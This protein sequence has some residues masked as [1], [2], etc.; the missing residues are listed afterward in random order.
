MT[1]GLLLSLGLVVLAHLWRSTANRASRTVSW[2]EIHPDG[3][4]VVWQD[5]RHGFAGTRR[6]RLTGAILIA[7]FG[8]AD[9]KT[10]IWVGIAGARQKQEAAEIVARAAGARL[11]DEGIPP[12]PYSN[13]TAWRLGITE[14]KPREADALN[15]RERHLDEQLAPEQPTFPEAADNYFSDHNDALAVIC[16][17]GEKPTR[18]HVMAMTTVRGL[19]TDIT[20]AATV[21]RRFLPLSYAWVPAVLAAT[22][23]ALPVIRSSAN[24]WD[25]A[26]IAVVTAWFARFL[27]RSAKHPPTLV[28][29]R[30]GRVP[31]FTRAARKGAPLPVWQMGEWAAGTDRAGVHAPLKNAPAEVTQRSGACIGQDPR[32]VEC[33]LP[34]EDRYRGFMCYGDPGKGKSTLMRGMLKADADRRAEQNWLSIIWIETKS[35][36]EGAQPAAELMRNAGLNPLVLV[37]AEINGPRLELA[38]RSNPASAARLLTEAMRY[39]YDASDIYEQSAEILAA[40]FEAAAAFDPEDAARIGL[41]EEQPNLIEVAFRLLGG[42]P[43]LHERAKR[44]LADH[45]PETH[46]QKLQRY[47]EEGPRDYKMRVEPVRNKL[48]GLLAARGMFEPARRQSVTFGDLLAV[49]QPVV[50]DLAPRDGASGHYTNLTAQRMAAMAMFALWDTIRRTC[51]GWQAAGKNIAIYSDELKDV[52]GFGNGHLEVV[53]AIADQGRSLGVIPVFGTQRPDQLRDATREAVNSFGTQ[54]YFG[55]R[56]AESSALASNNL[57]EEYLPTE[58]QSLP[59]GHCAAS[60]TY[61]GIVRAAFTLKPKLVWEPSGAATPSDDLSRR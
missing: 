18:T 43:E 16:R 60:V 29:L 1:E 55:L 59:V 51:D 44:V 49:A 31:R 57:R 58:I 53:Q 50:L 25:Y 52:A 19:D 48:S 2:W 3:S 22:I 41:S 34:Y 35:A 27:W 30:T 24:V 54:F 39:A 7:R 56:A 13:G 40:V 36:K 61:D 21:R 15:A 9:Q 28:A 10:R 33:W 23:A 20:D 38:D 47:F 45:V 12:W 8:H 11:G 17:P 6:R 4:D 5:F 46:R 32:G 26:A 14:P 42:I 37:G